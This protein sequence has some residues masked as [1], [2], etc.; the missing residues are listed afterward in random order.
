MKIL[1]VQIE[2]TT[3]SYLNDGIKVYNERLKNY[4]SF[5]PEQISMPK[6]IRQQPFDEQKKADALEI[7]TLLDRKSVE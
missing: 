7:Q 3:D 1:L 2:K 6:N 5:T 4:V